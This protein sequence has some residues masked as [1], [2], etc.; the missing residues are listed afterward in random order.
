M[1]VVDAM[2]RS[3]IAT[4][5]AALVLAQPALPARVHSDRSA[6]VGSRSSDTEVG[7]D[8]VAPDKSTS[9]S[10]PSTWR[11]YVSKVLDNQRRLPSEPAAAI[12]A[13]RFKVQP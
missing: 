5:L 10:D 13:S 7:R 9:A 3:S 2:N 12:G 8:A 6:K 11:W 4:A 1:T